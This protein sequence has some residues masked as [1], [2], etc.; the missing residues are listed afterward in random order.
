MQMMMKAN[1]DDYPE[2]KAICERVENVEGIKKYLDSQ[3][4]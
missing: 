2:I 1:L 3:N 4:N